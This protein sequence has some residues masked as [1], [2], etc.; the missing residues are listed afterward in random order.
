[1]AR[2]SVKSRPPTRKTSGGSLEV[3]YPSSPARPP[4]INLWIKFGEDFSMLQ[5]HAF[6]ARWAALKSLQIALKDREYLEPDDMGWYETEDGE[7]RFRLQGDVEGLIDEL[8][9]F[10]TDWMPPQPH[11]NDLLRAS[12]AEVVRH[13]TT[14]PDAD[15]P[16]RVKKVRK[17]GAAP[18]SRDGLITLAEIC[19]ELNIEPRDA[20]KTLRN[21]VEKP[22]AGWAWEAAEAAK[23]KAILKK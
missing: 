16:N 15:R 20:R 6:G 18:I 8:E 14:T 4:T 21:K 1:M 2:R 17:P 10:D 9:E 11:L 12:G 5:I 3:A 7:L 19:E 22:D 23:V 13:D